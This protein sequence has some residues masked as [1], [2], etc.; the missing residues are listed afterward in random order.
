MATSYIVSASELDRQRRVNEQ[1]R[2]ALESRIVIELAMGMLAAER[3]I[4]VDQAF[5]VLRRH[6]RSHNATLRSVAHA[7]VSTGLRP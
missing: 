4:P 6:A 1:L 5:E 7:V 2:E 3:G